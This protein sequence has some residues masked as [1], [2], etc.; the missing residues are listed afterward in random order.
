MAA[1]WVKRLFSFGADPD[2]RNWGSGPGLGGWGAEGVPGASAQPY[3]KGPKGYHRSDARILEDV[4][5]RLMHEPDI[6]SSEVEVKVEQGE[7]FLS[8]TVPERE[9]KRLIE[10][11]AAEVPG[12]FDIS[13]QLHVKWGRGRDA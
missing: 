8:G 9:M 1:T 4:C 3:P 11:I 2:Q 6:D 10:E 7:V 5:E 13:N 12:V